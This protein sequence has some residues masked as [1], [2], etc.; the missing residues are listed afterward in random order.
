[1]TATAAATAWEVKGTITLACNCDWGCPC[2]FN[3]RPTYGHC[4]G[5]WTWHV[6]QFDHSGKYAAVA[7]FEDSG[8]PA[9]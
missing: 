5:E 9:R 7:P 3:A 2:N 8:P 4:E 6:P 1:M